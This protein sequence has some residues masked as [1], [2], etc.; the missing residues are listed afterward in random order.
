MLFTTL[1][2][3]VL[4]GSL[5]LAIKEEGIIVVCVGSN[6]KII[7]TLNVHTMLRFHHQQNEGKHFKEENRKRFTV[8]SPSPFTNLKKSELVRGL[9]SRGHNTATKSKPE[10]Q[11]ELASTLKGIQRPPAY[12]TTTPDVS[13]LIETY[14][15]PPCEPLH[16]IANIV[17]NLIT[18]L[19]NHIDD[20]D[21]QKDFEK[22]SA[23][24][25]GDKNQIRLCDARLFAVK[26]AK[27]AQMKFEDKKN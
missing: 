26:L 20:Q 15:I 22:F 11:E 27:F 24:T 14:D 2:E 7:L 25:I 19:P 4:P 5:R 8:N 10:L 17:Q 3:M 16:D 13:D 23:T 9:K 6:Q 18:E 21:T 1:V 12:F